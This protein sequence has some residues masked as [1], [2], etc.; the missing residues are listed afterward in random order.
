M[1]KKSKIALFS[2]VAALAASVCIALQF[3]GSDQ[4]EQVSTKTATNK[5]TKK[6]NTKALEELA[7]KLARK[8]LKV[9]LPQKIAEKVDDEQL[10]A[11]LERRFMIDWIVAN[12]VEKFPDRMDAA[13]E[14]IIATRPMIVELVDTQE[15]FLNFHKDCELEDGATITASPKKLASDYCF[16]AQ[17]ELY[18]ANEESIKFRVTYLEELDQTNDPNSAQLKKEL[19]LK[20]LEAIRPEALENYVTEHSLP[21]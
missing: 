19:K 15:K 17:N 9:T 12:Y 7:L 14:D 21:S 13:L 2:V 1:T 10:K 20:A 18:L 6:K 11:D 5:V 8:S 3:S 16:E 4:I